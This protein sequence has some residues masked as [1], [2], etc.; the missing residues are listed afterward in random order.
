LAI[1]GA[2]L[3]WALDNTLSRA[4]A[5][6]DPVVVVAGK[7]ALGALLTA[8]VAFAVG[9]PRP[10]KMGPVLVLCLCGA[11]G[12]G[13]SLRLYLLAQRHI[14]AARTASIFALA[15]FIGAALGWVLQQTWPTPWSLLAA[16]CF[17]LGVFLHATE[18]HRHP[19]AHPRLEHEH[20][21]RHDDGHHEHLHDPPFTGE[22]SHPH[23]HE[24]VE[25]EHDHLPDA[26][27]EHEPEQG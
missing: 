23:R 18:R 14:G 7:G 22:H 6:H 11:T 16:A 12:Y 3:G 1:A 19:H 8:A 9:A 20:P 15:P 25:H 2:T 5:E 21:H 24:P 17:G 27:H 4:L 13:L 26:H 10:D